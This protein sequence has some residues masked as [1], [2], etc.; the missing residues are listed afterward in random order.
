MSLILPHS[1][2]IAAKTFALKSVVVDCYPITTLDDFASGIQLPPSRPGSCHYFH[3]PQ[4]H[5]S[6]ASYQS[7][8][9]RRLEPLP[10]ATTGGDH[11]GSTI[12]W[13]ATPS[14]V[15]AATSTEGEV[16]NIIL[17]KNLNLAPKVVQIQVLELLRTKRLFTRTGTLVAPHQFL[18]VALLSADSGGEARLTPHLNDFM[19]FAHWHNPE[20]GFTKL[21][22]EWEGSSNSKA[23]DRANGLGSHNNH[24]DGGSESDNDDET[25]SLKSV[26]RTKRGSQSDGGGRHCS[27]SSTTSHGFGVNEPLFTEQDLSAFAKQSEE[28]CV[29]MDVVRYQMNLV[30]FLRMHRAVSGGISPQATKH[31]DRLMRCLAPLHGIDFVTP[32]LVALA[33]KKVYPHRIRVTEPERERSVQWGSAVRSIQEILQDTGPGEIIDYVL[34]MVATPL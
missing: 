14:T 16:A 7:T 19:Y 31:F 11:R 24:R 34:H 32:S 21:D 26:V 25:T 33:A 10:P 18:L 1:C 2:Q 29:D 12:H 8:Q 23:K 13:P 30:S 5:F 9:S 20:D 4:A 6:H 28:V 17:A 22:A 3:E 15:M 27:T